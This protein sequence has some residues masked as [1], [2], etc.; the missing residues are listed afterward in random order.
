[1]VAGSRS[2]YTQDTR[3]MKKV[4]TITQHCKN[5]FRDSGG[6]KAAFLF[7]AFIGMTALHAQTEG[8]DHDGDTLRILPGNNFSVSILN[9]A[10]NQLQLE[11]QNKNTDSITPVFVEFSANG[12]RFSQ[13][14]ILY[15]QINNVSVERNIEK[16]WGPEFV[17]LGVG[18]LPPL[19]KYV[20]N[21]ALLNGIPSGSSIKVRVFGSV[22][23]QN[24]LWSG[25][26]KK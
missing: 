11:L 21:L 10:G 9:S 19:G 3:S 4:Y 8:H 17:S 14:C 1:M 7:F 25:V 18:S 2:I 22:T 13:D 6:I 24:V 20:M 26:V 15:Q 5:K 12:F 23:G 16:I